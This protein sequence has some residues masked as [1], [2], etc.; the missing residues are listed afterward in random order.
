LSHFGTTDEPIAVRKAIARDW[1]EDLSEF[2]P[3]QID[4]ACREWRRTKPMRPA[5]SDI[6][7]MCITA[8]NQERE[9]QKLADRS[10]QGLDAEVIAMW[11]Q[12]EYDGDSRSWQQRRGDAIAQN[13]ERFARS[14]AWRAGKLDEYDAVHHPERLAERQRQGTHEAAQQPFS[15]PSRSIG[16]VLREM[17]ITASEPADHAS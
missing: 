14:A 5:I 3:R 8:Q 7:S 12:P 1:V 16:E 17:G 10:R 15:T 11:K 4:D 13:E 2:S 6:R 9:H